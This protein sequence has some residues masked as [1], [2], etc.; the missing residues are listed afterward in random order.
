MYVHVCRVDIRSRA[1]LGEGYMYDN[2]EPTNKHWIYMYMNI[3]HSCPLLPI[4]MYMHNALPR[5]VGTSW[6]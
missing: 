2:S 5:L 3:G 1:S 4:Y 6:E